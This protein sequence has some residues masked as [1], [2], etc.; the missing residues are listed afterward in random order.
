MYTGDLS[1]AVIGIN[2]AEPVRNNGTNNNYDYRVA[3][4][5]QNYAFENKAFKM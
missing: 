4:K 1:L 5:T 3:M 2:S